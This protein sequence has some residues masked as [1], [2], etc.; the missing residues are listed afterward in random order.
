MKFLPF[1]VL[2]W[3]ILNVTSTIWPFELA[4]SFYRWAYA[5][6][7]HE[8]WQV[9]IQIWSGGAVDRLYQALPILF[10]WEI[11]FLPLCVVALNHRCA[12]AEREHKAIE[13]ERRQLI[14]KAEKGKVDEMP[15][16]SGSEGA[17]SPVDEKVH[18]FEADVQRDAYSPS[19]PPPV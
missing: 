9:L 2:T 18:R 5:L 1:F 14:L 16:R 13:E 7:A 19:V 11:V 15:E 10:T 12:V 8:V 3:V 4:P 17:P 6:P